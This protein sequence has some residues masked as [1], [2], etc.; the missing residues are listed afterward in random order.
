MANP[1]DPGGFEFWTT[2]IDTGAQSQAQALVLMTQ[3]NEYVLQTVDAAV[4]YL[5]G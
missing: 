4:D 2:E 1:Q 3:S 5:V